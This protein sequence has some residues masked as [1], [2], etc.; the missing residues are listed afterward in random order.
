MASLVHEWV[1]QKGR[2]KQ[3]VWGRG[4]R[5]TGKKEWELLVASLIGFGRWQ[6]VGQ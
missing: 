6:E 4:G 5:R 1:R 3:V 2:G